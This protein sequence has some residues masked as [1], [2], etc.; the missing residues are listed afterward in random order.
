M[1]IKTYLV[2]QDYDVLKDLLKKDLMIRTDV[3]IVVKQAIGLNIA[4]MCK[5]KTENIFCFLIDNEEKFF[6]IV[7][8]EDVAKW[9]ML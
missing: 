9:D 5:R 1:I 8:V 2:Q 4:L 7:N 6:M 3:L